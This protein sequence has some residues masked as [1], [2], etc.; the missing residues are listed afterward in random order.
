M[1]SKRA[2]RLH[3][4][5]FFRLT[6]WYAFIFAVCAAIAFVFFYS[7]IALAL[8]K[9]VD[10]E[11]TAQ[12]K[13][14]SALFSTRGIEAVSQALLLEAKAAGEKRN[15]YRL[16]SSSGNEFS[17]SNPTYWQDIRINPAAVQRLMIDG[18]QVVTTETLPES[19]YAVRILYGRLG[20]G[21]FL[22]V[23]RVMDAMDRILAAFGKMFF[24]TVTVLLMLASLVGGFMAQKALSGVG[25]VTR[26]ARL[27]SEG[28]DLSRR[29]PTSGRGD[30]ID[31]L[32]GTFN[33]MLDRIQSLILGTRQ[34]GDN[35]A[36]DLKGPI[37]RIRGMAEVTLTTGS[38]LPDY[39]RLAADT[40]EACDRLLDM[41]NTMLT[42]SKTE[43]G[44]ESLDVSTV[45]LTRVV[46]DACE[47]FEPLAEDKGIRLSWDAPEGVVCTGDVGKLQRM[48]ANLVDN[49]VK[50]TPEG[51]HVEVKM[52]RSADG[53]RITV[54]DS[55]PGIS[56][57]DKDRIFERF[58]RGD[59]SRSQPGS[60]LGLS[61]ARAVAR[62]HGGDI[63]VENL[64][65]SG[66]R[67]SIRL[68]GKRQYDQMVMLGSCSGQI[69]G[70]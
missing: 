66:A 27:I 42:I 4:R 19:G 49:A 69:D 70:V 25:T 62:A 45:D 6:A 13:K 23:G 44:A 16:F 30:E 22:Q 58:Y 51:G 14:L 59:S 63:T 57:E 37:T 20:P 52:T 43:A 64:E 15:F 38:A 10:Q 46:A 7:L 2:N 32:A 55:G 1:S 17:A 39:E 50:Y 18:G 11:L 31:L 8:E 21:V 33:Q 28:G 24:L 35:I 29:V 26:E 67:F 12:A 9:Q 68:N 36:H 61:L 54:T 65:G 40:I 3:H 60:G 47:I 48:M 5:L 53:V 41:I 34:M 56:L